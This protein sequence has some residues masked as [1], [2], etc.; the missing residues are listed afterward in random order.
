MVMLKYLPTGVTIMKCNSGMFLL[1]TLLLSS[2]ASAWGAPS[3][4]ISGQ[5][6]VYEMRGEGLEGVA[7]IDVTVKYDSSRMTNPRVTQKQL[8]AGA[9]MM[10]NLSVPGEVRAVIITSKPI[11]GSG[12]ILGIEFTVFGD[13]P[14]AITSLTAKLSSATLSDLPVQTVLA[15]ATYN[16]VA[17][18][19]SVAQPTASV[20]NPTTTSSGQ[21]SSTQ[22]ASG[23]TATTQA[24]S[25]V[26]G[27]PST[28]GGA[29]LSTGTTGGTSGV[30][31]ETSGVS[32]GRSSLTGVSLAGL[33]EAPVTPPPALPPDVPGVTKS[34]PRI[35]P[36]R[37]VAGD[38]RQPRAPEVLPEGSPPRSEPEALK[39]LNI[40]PEAAPCKSVLVLFKEFSGPRTPQTLTNLF[41]LAS[42]PGVGQ[43]PTIALSD[44]VS[45]VKI[46]VEDSSSTSPNFSVSGGKLLSL[47]KDSGRY[48]L[49]I[50]PDARTSEVT[51]SVLKQGKVT[52]I[53]LLV[54]PPLDIKLLPTGKL[55]EASFTLYLQGTDKRAGDINGDGVRNY[56]DDY[57]VTAHYLIL[58][59][60]Q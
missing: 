12:S 45:K 25:V 34:E 54:V 9:I 5:G 51:V 7:G 59:N 24:T 41:S 42:I 32:G 18:S 2:V 53:P 40:K 6:S 23:S 31:G 30:S 52:T 4:I 15:T 3:L 20:P 26:A 16:D 14:G 49:E 37:E 36:N 10:P 19:P 27:T 39:P 33:G 57:I 46:T 48:L 60:K 44:G 56:L 11:T 38:T 1:M 13:R 58:K 21:S 50:I 28:T 43:V 35:E 55:D 47:K 29:A 8:I 17:A 22:T